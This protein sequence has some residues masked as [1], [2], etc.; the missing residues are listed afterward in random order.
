MNDDRDDEM[1]TNGRAAYLTNNVVHSPGESPDNGRA[2]RYITGAIIIICKPPPRT[3]FS[4]LARA[5]PPVVLL[6][7]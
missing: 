2:A 1:E 7:V 6:A 3:S 5:F 4:Y